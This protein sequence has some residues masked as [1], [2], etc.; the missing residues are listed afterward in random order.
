MS[1]FCNNFVDPFHEEK[2][3][4]LPK[5]LLKLVFSYNQW[6][7]GEGGGEGEAKAQG[8]QILE[9]LKNFHL[10]CVTCTVINSI[11]KFI[12]NL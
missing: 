11:P 1:F 2:S 4:I 5:Q 8:L 7:I 10:C 12:N 3:K 9:A 6:Q